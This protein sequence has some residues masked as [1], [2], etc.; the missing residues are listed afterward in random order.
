M[1][2][3]RKGLFP[4]SREIQC[5]VNIIVD[6]FHFV[7][8]VL[9][10]ASPQNFERTIPIV[11]MDSGMNLKILVDKLP[12]LMDHVQQ[13]GTEKLILGHYYQFVQK[14]IYLLQYKNLLFILCYFYFTQPLVQQLGRGKLILVNF[15]S[16]FRH[17]QIHCVCKVFVFLECSLFCPTNLYILYRKYIILQV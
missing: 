6:L 14:K 7:E 1:V 10:S 17:V 4:T 13:L 12:H 16:N 11:I 9:H 3:N 5:S 8:L 2:Q 15:V